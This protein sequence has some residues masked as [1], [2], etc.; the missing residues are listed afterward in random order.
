MSR[1][2]ELITRTAPGRGAARPRARF[3]TDAAEL[4]LAGR[5][6]FSYH[7]RA[8]RAP[9]LPEVGP[10]TITVPG[11]WQ[12][13][14][15]GSPAYTNVTFPFPVDPPHVPDVNPAGDYQ[16]D[17]ELPEDLAGLRVLLRLDGVDNAAAIWFNG[18]WVGETKGSRNT[19]EFDL[20]AHARPGAN[21]L[22]VRVVQWSAAS[23]LEDQDMW[24]LSGIFRPIAI[25][26]RPENGIE[27]VRIRADYD[28][29]TG[30]GTLTVDVDSDDPAPQIT[31]EG[32]HPAIR[33]GEPTTIAHVL[34]WSAE[35]PHLYTL[36]VRTAGERT[37]F[38]IG[39]RTVDIVDAQLRVNGTPLRF[40]GVN[41]HDHHPE[42]GRA[43]TLEEVRTDLL[44]M[45][46]HNVNAVRTAHYPPLPGLLDLAD[47]L[48]L[49]V[50]DEADFESHG[51][52]EVG[53][54][55]NVTDDPS[56]RE[57]LIDRMQRMVARDRNH[58][59]VIMWS[60]GNESGPGRNIEHMRDA[61]LD[62]DGTRP[63]H[64]ERD[65]T[66]EHSDVMSL[67]YTP[68]DVLERIGR[69]DGA[70]GTASG[71]TETASGTRTIAEA[72]ALAN[73]PFILVEYA[74]AMGTGPGGLREYE[75]L[76]RTYP[77]LQGGFI[78][79]WIEH[80]LATTAPGGGRRYAYGGD[81]GEPVHSS[82]FVADGLLAPDR[83][84]RPGLLDLKAV[85]APLDLQLQAG[86]LRVSN[87]FDVSDTSGLDFVAQWFDGDGN[88]TQ[89]PL[90]VPVVAPGEHT[91]VPL[92]VPDG[93]AL[94]VISARLAQATAWAEAGHEIAVVDQQ[95]GSPSLREPLA[96]EW[97]IGSSHIAAAE[98]HLQ[99]PTFGAWRAPTDNDRAVRQVELGS[100]SD[101]AGWAELNLHAPGGRTVSWEQ[102][103]SATRI[104]RRWGFAGRDVGF[105]E[106]TRAVQRDGVLH[107]D[108]AFV[109]FGP[110]P[111]AATVARLGLDFELP[112]LGPGTQLRWFGRGFGHAYPDTGAGMRLGWFDGTVAELQEHY[113]RPQDNGVRSD[114]RA[115]WIEHGEHTLQIA[116][117]PF[118]FSLRPW[119]DRELDTAAHPDELPHTDRLV[120]SLNAAVHGIG[121]AACGPG[122]LPQHRLHPR[123][124]ELHLQL[125]LTDRS[126]S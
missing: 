124:A 97:A 125:S 10:D 120:L 66:F 63:I 118:S 111:V 101:S 22:R 58:P 83:T 44:L 51:F 115:L 123:P 104:V 25:L 17:V 76:F 7:P 21:D 55:A 64:Y 116:G 89:T 68:V 113:L 94:V 27:D 84:P 99:G 13:Q 23:Y 16:R 122:V 121:T 24:W 60:L 36:T 38:R 87:R 53:Y 54:R 79:E 103:G 85:Y 47:E 20:T 31:L 9:E 86:V 107:L 98:V 30:A 6:K 34:P 61:A 92:D 91:S 117:E 69:F 71:A 57:A 52:V 77:R 28:H 88:L 39:F 42:R 65:W 18:A 49:W 100:I 72:A 110:W 37:E 15:Y 29:T 67:M 112:G 19:H 5:W 32:D 106:T 126:T 70:A 73:K 48:G 96:R 95:L 41:R 90:A 4:D 8:D 12:L 40:R 1:T 105:T 56:Y 46:Q 35:D 93:A 3:H 74:H 26:L 33:S 80:G 109:P 43:V 78:W 114:V 14:G 119:N 81:F 62:L 108:A 82:N 45:K 75:E 102:E 59:S 50:I 11:M 2:D